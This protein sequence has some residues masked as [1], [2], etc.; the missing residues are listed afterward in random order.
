MMKLP[1]SLI[2]NF[3]NIN[4][5]IEEI[6]TAL[7]KSGIEVDKIENGTCPF[8]MVVCAKILSKEKHPDADKLSLLKVFDGEKE[9]QIVCGAS[10][11]KEGMLVALAKIGASLTDE[12]G[13]TWTIKESKIRGI[14]SFGMLCSKQELQ[15]SQEN[16][17]IIE[18]PESIEVGTDLIPHLWDP[19]FEL[20]LTPNLGHCFSALGVARELSCFL[21]APMKN[22]KTSFSTNN[23][24]IDKKLKAHVS[25]NNCSRYTL[26]YLENVSVEPSPF[27]L[28]LLLERS[29]LRSVNN[30]V[31]ITNLVMLELGQPLHAF[32]YDLIEGA[33]LSVKDQIEKEEFEGL[34]H[35]KRTI[36]ENTLVICDE[37]KPIAI[38][39]IIG[40]SNSAVSTNTKKI[41]L[42]AA[43]FNATSIRK[44]AKALGLRTDSAQRF[45]RKTDI[46]LTEKAL[47]RVCYYLQQSY[48]VSICD[49]FID[50]QKHSY[51]EKIISLRVERASLLLGRHLSQ[52]E[53][54]E[55]FTK[56]QL[57][58]NSKDGIIDVSVPSFRQDLNIEEDL[59]EEIV[60][61]YGYDHLKGK[62]PKYTTSTIPHDRLFLFEKKLRDLLIQQGLSE[63]LTCDLISP[64]QKDLLH[65]QSLFDSSIIK[66]MHAKS[67]D[68]SILRPSLLPG[69]L[70]SLKQNFS[71]QNN[72]IA[73]F[74]IGKVHLKEKENYMEPTL[75]SILLSGNNLKAWNKKEEPKDFFDLKGIL[76][77]IFSSLD[78]KATYSPSNHPSFHPFRQAQVYI[79]D[80]YVGVL[81]ELDQSLCKKMQ[82]KKRVLFA[83]MQSN[84]LLE[85]SINQKRF[86][87]LPTQP[88]SERDI[89]ILVNKRMLVEDILSK[90]RKNKP[91]I[92]EKV[93]LIDL[94]EDDKIGDQNKNVTIRFVYRDPIR[95]LSFDEIEAAHQSLI[96]TISF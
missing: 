92:L 62:K 96:S 84:L 44:S 14:K 26:R 52:S 18:L 69:M 31:D 67:V 74:E 20:S 28:Q 40:G 13:K 83:E 47:N 63:W 51:K 8:S 86:K 27:W 38:G 34:D 88:S 48:G 81:G 1:L 57:P 37:I 61:V 41:V 5:S 10:N 70:Q 43:N 72:D 36:S 39:G 91:A 30:V 25:S 77:N 58:F 55:I 3:V 56:L 49:S 33:S 45:E 66:V 54:E 46:N 75:F 73:A 65:E 76:E 78:L 89:T 32:D 60:R 12:Q 87:K 4:H 24:A 71:F 53:I 64:K 93:F 90:Y 59:I 15:V 42:E 29:G 6:A 68:Y 95:T 11:C 50:I 79:D 82:I 23:I 22:I 17:G 2:K 85:K 16:E 94:F 35:I 19:V 80:I 21:N 9:L 7:T